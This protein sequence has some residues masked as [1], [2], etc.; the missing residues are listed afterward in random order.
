MKLI[1]QSFKLLAISE[2]KET[3]I[4]LDQNFATFE[5]I[6][7]RLNAFKFLAFSGI[8]LEQADNQQEQNELT[9][10]YPDW[11]NIQKVNDS[12]KWYNDTL[13]KFPADECFNAKNTRLTNTLEFHFLMHCI[14]SEINYQRF[15]EKS[16][17]AKNKAEDL[18]PGS[19]K[20]KVLVT[21]SLK[22]WQNIIKSKSNKDLKFF[23]N[24][25]KIILKQYY[26]KYF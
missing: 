19:I 17:T 15:I 2:G 5:I 7:S 10:V 22:N 6:T 8:S 13:Q 12:L 9:F 23:K 1:K 18:L 25:I 26:P 16:K 14:E 21:A 4:D 20:T 3:K 11:A 24:T